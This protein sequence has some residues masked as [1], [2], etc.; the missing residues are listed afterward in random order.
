MALDVGKYHADPA[1]FKRL[2]EEM[3]AKNP[4]ISLGSEYAEFITNNQ[5]RLLIRLARYKFVARMLKRG[6]RVLEIGSGSGLGAIFLGQHCASVVGL[7]VNQPELEHARALN[8]RDNVT[9]IDQDFFQFKDDAGFDAVVSLDVI[10]HVPPDQA[11]GF[12]AKTASLLRQSG[13]A[14]IGTPSLFSYPHQGE[15]SRASHERCYDLPE[16]DALMA[17]C[18]GRTFPF[19]MNDEIV[20]TGHH[21]MAW[22]YFVIGVVP[23][24]PQR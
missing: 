23:T 15:M 11:Q 7:E 22:Y 13:A 8:R 16:L 20:H 19:S 1:L 4:P 12:V 6:D 24:A 18:F 3:S 14:I 10:E 17:P 9:F 5:L 2:Y 21:K